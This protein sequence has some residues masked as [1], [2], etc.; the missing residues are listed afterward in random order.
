M[1]LDENQIRSD[2]RILGYSIKNKPT[3]LLNALR[4]D[5]VTG[6]MEWVAAPVV[7][8]GKHTSLTEREVGG[9]IDHADL[10]INTAKIQLLAITTALLNALS[11]TEGKIGPLAV[12]EGKIAALAVTGAKIA[13]LTIANAK[14]IDLNAAK[15]TGNLALARI[16]NLLI[17]PAK[18]NQDGAVDGQVLTWNN[19]LGRW[20]PQAGGGGG[21]LG[22]LEFLRDKRLAGDLIL[23]RGFVEGAGPLNIVSIIPAAGKTFFIASSNMFMN[24]NSVAVGPMKVE[25]K[26]D[27]SLV[28]T[29]KV[30]LATD[31]SV[32][33]KPIIK[34]D[35][36]VGD[37][38]KF[39]TMDKLSGANGLE[40]DGTIEGWIQ[41]T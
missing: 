18:I 34:S 12:T 13:A 35:A 39:Y 28:E 41:T 33:N 31:E 20:E 14:I 25:L 11:V 21:G 2:N 1:P 6:F 36:L 17:T 37:G 3:A 8:D 29:V 22:D 40:V 7:F 10:S 38:V 32:V 16:A 26:N 4:F 19:G 24:N 15:L 30:N 23:A 27:V 5:S 9:E